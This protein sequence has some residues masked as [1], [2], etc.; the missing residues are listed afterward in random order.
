MKKYIIVI[1][2][3]VIVAGAILMMRSR[4]RASRVPT[5]NVVVDRTLKTGD[6]ITNGN[7]IE[8]VQGVLVRAT[9]VPAQSG[10]VPK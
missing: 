1:V 10:Q 7:S 8:R 9:N 6:L 2:V 4:T 5:P 3:F